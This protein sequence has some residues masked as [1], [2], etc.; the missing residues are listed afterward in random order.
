MFPSRAPPFP[1]EQVTGDGLEHD[2]CLLEAVRLESEARMRAVGRFLVAASFVLLL[3]AFGT[4]ASAQ[5]TGDLRGSVTDGAGGALPGVSVEI[6]S[7]ALQGRRTAVADAAG[8]F[9]FPAV[10]PGTYTLTASLA[11]FR[12]EEVFPVRVALGETVT[13]P[14]PLAPAAEAEVEVSAEV[15]LVDTASTKIGASVPAAALAR[16]PLGRNFASVMLTVGGTG[17]DIAGNTVYGATG[18]ENSYIV[19]GLNTT[20]VLQGMQGKQL[21]LE[22]V[23]EVEVRTGGYEAEYGRAMGGSVNVVTKSGGNEFHGDLFGYY[24]SDSLTASDEHGEERTALAL[25]QP[26]PSTKLDAG[27]DLGGYFLKDRL[28][29]FG[30][31]DRVAQDDDYQRGES[32][33]YTPTS[34]T[35]NYVSGTDTTRRDLYSGKLTLRAAVSQTFVL[36]VFG[37][38]G[39]LDG[40]NGTNTVG[41]PSAV[42]R[43]E[44]NGGTDV[45]AR[46]EGLFGTRFLAQAQYGYHEEGMDW[47]SRHPQG[48]PFYDI[49]RGYGQY[50]PGS[51]FGMVGPATMRRN[52]WSATATGFLGGHEVKA[53]VGYEHLNSSWTDVWL[54]GGT[55]TRWYSSGGAFLY[56]AHRSF[57][58]VPLNCQL[59]TDGSSGSFG[60]VDPT[61]CN[62]WESTDRAEIDPRTRNLAFFVQDSWKVLP[63]L[64]LNAGL[65]YED[66]RIYDA[67]GEPR[68]ELTNQWSPRVGV[69]WDPRADGR[70][71]IYASYGRYYQ[72]IPQAIQIL[73]LGG[74]YNI[75][76]Y[77]YTEDRL[78]LVNDGNLAPFEYLAGSDYVPD[79][80]KGI[81]QDE[82]VAGA[83][84]ELWRDWSVG[85]KGIYRSLGRTIEDRCDVFDPRSG[86][87]DLV[88]AEAFTSCVMMNPGEGRYGQLSDLANPDCWEGDPAN[89]T[90][91]PCESVRASRVFRG[92]ELEVRRRFSE[93]FQLQASWLWSKLTGNY[94]GFVNEQRGQ[95]VPTLNVDF[96]IP[97]LLPNSRGALSLDRTHQ[98]RLTGFYSFPFG[99]QTGVNAS[100]ATG[101]P[102]SIM[103]RASPYYSGY[104]NYLEPRGS[105]DELPSTYNVD[106]HLE[107]PLRLGPIRLTPVVDVFN[108]TNVQTAT[109]RGEVYNTLRTGNQSPPYTSPTVPSFGKDTAWQKPR[110]VRL[111]ARVS[112]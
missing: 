78:D 34:V 65:R 58:K 61:T 83:E 9:R 75:F 88:P 57:A 14:V 96:D 46:W 25:A 26:E 79:E 21:N 5:T 38:P 56:A 41:P 15:P 70:S 99:L 112:F 36:S 49:R 8:L 47:T 106:L 31:Y 59:R 97:E 6:R 98:V 60:F 23:Q 43:V 10:P 12:R 64:T 20:G 42:L 85:L 87:A 82:V 37:D 27:G 7:P 104:R 91:K 100:F 63:N 86:L 1:K 89:G 51:G 52:S 50:A 45:A 110:V 76:A 80:L 73:A 101:A 28:W 62:A 93:R 111:G 71:K 40:R 90:P 69:V 103:G 19:D 81:Y 72:A 53:G 55:V 84:V 13:V 105:W 22:F 109:R 108:L 77:N 92:L 102:L 54:N 35:T 33:T 44:E 67:A 95:A 74:E 29:F 66:Q 16:L 68:I 48:L 39:T 3:S 24:D 107:F 11:G 94:D 30:A 32:L 17:T 2:G 18:L 4:T